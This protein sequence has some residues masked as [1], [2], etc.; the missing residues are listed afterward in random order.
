VGPRTAPAPTGWQSCH[1]RFPLPPE[2]AK[3][4]FRGGWH[5][6]ETPQ[7]LRRPTQTRQAP[8]ARASSRGVPRCWL[9]TTPHER[10]TGTI[11][12]RARTRTKTP[13]TS[14]E[15]ISRLRIALRSPQGG[16]GPPATE[17]CRGRFG[18]GPK[19]DRNRL[20]RSLVQIGDD[21]ATPEANPDS[22]STPGTRVLER[23]RSMLAGYHPS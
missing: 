2:N 14:T 15:W 13:L 16:G 9:D 3:I 21:P 11:H 1:G 19:K 17:H 23:C 4:A 12:D 7:P 5:R 10:P 20:P 18:G 6:S 22:P 8:P